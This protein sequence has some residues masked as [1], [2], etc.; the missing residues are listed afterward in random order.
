MSVCARMCVD[1]RKFMC[2]WPDC[3][4]SFLHAENLTSHRRQHTDP[5]PFRCEECPL[6]YWQKS[7]LRSHRLKAHGPAAATQHNVD[8]SAQLLASMSS[9][10]QLVDGIIKSVSAS[11]QA[12]S[13]STANCSND[14]DDG[15]IKQLASVSDST[16]TLGRPVSLDG[17]DVGQEAG[18]PLSAEPGHEAGPQLTRPGTDEV[19]ERTDD[20]VIPPRVVDDLP[21]EQSDVVKDEDQV[22]T[23]RSSEPLNVYEFCEDE[24]VD[25]CRPKPSRS[26]A[27]APRTNTELTQ[28]TIEL[29]NHSDD[30]DEDHDLMAFDDDMSPTVDRLA[31]TV[32]TY[33][34]KKKQPSTE[35]ENATVTIS[36]RLSPSVKPAAKKSSR[37][38]SPTV[39]G[40]RRK[41]TGM[42]EVQE[43][44]EEPV[45]K[46]VRRKRTIDGGGDVD[47]DVMTC[48]PLPQT[49]NL[50]KQAAKSR[51]TKRSKK[52]KTC[53]D[54]RVPEDNGRSQKSSANDDVNSLSLQ[55]SLS[56]AVC[57]GKKRTRKSDPP[58]KLES[59]KPSP[60]RTASDV[61]NI[62]I[63]SN[64]I[65]KLD[66]TRDTASAD[67]N[68]GNQ[69][70]RRK[71]KGWRR[72]TK[73]QITRKDAEVEQRSKED[74][75]VGDGEI[76]TADESLMENVDDSAA[77]NAGEMEEREAVVPTSSDDERVSDAELTDA[78]PAAECLSENT[79]ILSL[80]ENIDD[81]DDA[82]CTRRSSPAS[83][84]SE[85]HEPCV[86]VPPA[87]QDDEDSKGI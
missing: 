62:N 63:D 30:D 41:R 28:T 68:T 79:E 39:A 7:S 34:R 12:S 70:T 24:A 69:A 4:K 14:T 81:A 21:S 17:P 76:A 3:R 29:N 80:N 54:G 20:D 6:A 55:S 13:S 18:R 86:L 67:T 15:N 16:N 19:T 46:K 45:K 73:R 57:D 35:N 83:Y 10:G 65:E 59:H 49:S 87:Q 31:E 8:K 26:S 9:A 50:T 52:D 25:I 5:K 56:T 44:T 85:E 53:A 42:A 74:G 36:K 77:G 64:N 32:I 47:K 75:D 37:R 58:T 1:N 78:G 22:K 84:K 71:G 82:E 51:N 43:D 38:K 61:R 27:A 66:M 40:L 23:S 33:S 11:M 72:R 60:D 48:N 2:D